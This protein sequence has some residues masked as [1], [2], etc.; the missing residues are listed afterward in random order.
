[1]TGEAQY[2]HLQLDHQCCQHR[3]LRKQNN[4]IR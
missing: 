1:M 3:Y 2:P 4:N